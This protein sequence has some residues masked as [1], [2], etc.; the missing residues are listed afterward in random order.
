[1]DTSMIHPLPDHGSSQPLLSLCTERYRECIRTQPC[2][3]LFYEFYGTEE[4][5]TYI[6]TGCMDLLTDE[7]TESGNFIEPYASCQP[8]S[9][10]PGRRYF[11]VRFPA[12]ML[13]GRRFPVEYLS[14][15]I[16]K[17]P[18]FG[19]RADW[20]I[21]SFRP[22]QHTM[23]LSEPVR[24]MLEHLCLSHGAVTVRELSAA[25]NYSER[26]IH[27]LFLSHM[28]FGPKHFSRIV[29]F[30]SALCE[31]QKAPDKNNSNFITYLGYSDQAH[32]QREFKEFTGV[33]PRQYINLYLTTTLHA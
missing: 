22:E 7:D 3:L 18:S 6:P 17:I 31:I 29:R 10:I 24:Y 12:G 23:P 11:G 27:R 28:G 15:G 21:K 25:L 33:T 16:R 2:R 9:C 14:A 30:Q 8:L 19:E 13:P 4:L 20:F 5:I 1:M 32:F 26:H